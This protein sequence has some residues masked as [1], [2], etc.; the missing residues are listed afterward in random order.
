MHEEKPSQIN[1]SGFTDNLRISAS[2]SVGGLRLEGGF[3]IYLSSDSFS[4]WSIG[5]VTGFA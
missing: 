3:T 1:F 2:S 4:L 5:V